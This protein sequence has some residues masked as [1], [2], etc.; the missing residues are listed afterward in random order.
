MKIQENLIP[1]S[2]EYLLFQAETIWLTRAQIAERFQATPQ[3][4]ML[5]QKAIFA[6]GDLGEGATC[7][8]HLRVRQGNIH[9]A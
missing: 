5:H 6:V 9:D 1:D 8:D 2:D 7:K 3:D 4:V